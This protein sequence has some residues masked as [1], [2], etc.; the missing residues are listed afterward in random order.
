MYSFW[1]NSVTAQ[2]LSLACDQECTASNACVFKSC[3]A[4]WD[5]GLEG[6]GVP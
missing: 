1:V 5:Q 3:S 6:G 2:G 4:G